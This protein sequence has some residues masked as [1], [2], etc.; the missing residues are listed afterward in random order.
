MSERWI[1]VLDEG[2]ASTRA[3]L[4]AADG[5]QGGMAQAPLDQH[6]PRPGWVEHDATEILEKTLACAREMVAKA[7][8]PDRIAAIGIANQRETV[9]AWD[10]STGRPIHRAIV[11]QD[12]RTAGF[13][14]S[15]RAA[16]HEALVQQRTGLL[17]DPYFSAGKMRWLLDNVPEALALGSRLAFGTIE[18]WLVWNLTGGAT[19]GVHVTDATNASR[20]SLMALEEYAWDA[21]LCELFGVPAAALPDIVSCAGTIA[22]TAPSMF[23]ASITISGLAGDQQAATIGQGCFSP[24]ETKATFGT[25]AFILTNM[26]NRRP[27]SA[28]R[29]LGTVLYDVG[30]ERCYALEGSVFAAGSAIK[31]LRDSLGLLGS[32]AESEA[33]ARSVP[34]NGGVVFVPGL[35][36]LG[37]PHWR[38]DATASLTGLTF[39]TT[40]AHIIRAALEAM[41]HQCHDL[42]AAFIA[43]GAGWNLLR[44]DGGMS[45]NDW[46]AQDLADML[47]VPCERPADVE[48]TARGAALLAAV[49]VGLYSTL[50]DAAAMLPPVARFV[51]ALPDEVREARLAAWRVALRGCFSSNSQIELAPA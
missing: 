49:G 51:T 5:T 19:G 31:W 50:A 1:L 9:V 13:C 39:A 21:E 41:A 17:L 3:V 46:L 14:E 47:E 48:T 23:G 20:T 45:C 34:D 7:G 6:Y 35:S 42:K 28:N 43:D 29:L 26:G 18:T 22:M 4:Y 44:I 40:R 27:H 2:T 8:G 25:G 10:K 38:P 37:A 12:R 32:A 30:G 36:G 16:G 15:L 33:L 11:W 24:G